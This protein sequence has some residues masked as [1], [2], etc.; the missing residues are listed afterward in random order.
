MAKE[1]LAKLPK[2]YICKTPM[3]EGSRL[4]QKDGDLY[5]CDTCRRLLS[6]VV[7][8]TSYN[9]FE[10]ISRIMAYR[11]ESWKELLEPW[12]YTEEAEKT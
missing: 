3:G 8:D 6:A 10:E 9:V 11:D 1:E 12:L 4:K 7:H 2:C 5:L